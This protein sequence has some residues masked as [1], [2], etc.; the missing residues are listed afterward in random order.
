MKTGTGKAIQGLSH[1]F[2]DSAAQVIRIP[3]EAILDNN[4][5]ILTIIK[6]VAHEA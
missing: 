6:G 4:K 2:T 3:I 5:G 1:I